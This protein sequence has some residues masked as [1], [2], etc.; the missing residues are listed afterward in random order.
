MVQL[1]LELKDPP[2]QE[3][4]ERGLGIQIRSPIRKEICLWTTTTS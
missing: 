4:L 3:D 1:V 2:S